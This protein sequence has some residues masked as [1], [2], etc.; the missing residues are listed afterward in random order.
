MRM[1]FV[2]GITLDFVIGSSLALGLIYR[3][4]GLVNIG[5]FAGWF[6]GSLSLLG[7][8]SKYALEKMTQ[9]Y[10]HRSLAW[11]IYDA[12]TDLA[13]VMLAV[14]LSWFVLAVVY[15]LMALCKAQFQAEQEKRLA[16]EKAQVNMVD[17]V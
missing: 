14:Y 16:D 10:T 2:V 4:P 6:I 9:E 11:R 13:Y 8:V 5:H 12:V 3:I 17:T 7:F 1:K 15:S